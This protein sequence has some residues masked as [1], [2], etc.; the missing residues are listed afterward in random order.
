MNHRLPQT[1]ARRLFLVLGVT[2]IV[3][4][5]LEVWLDH[6][7][8]SDLWVSHVLKED[9]DGPLKLDV[10]FKDDPGYGPSYLLHMTNTSNRP[11]IFDSTLLDVPNV[12]LTC[13]SKFSDS[14]SGV[15]DRIS[16]Q[17]NS[18]YVMKPGEVL[19]ETA[20]V[21]GHLRF[22]LYGSYQLNYEATIHYDVYDGPNRGIF[23]DPLYPSHYPGK[24]H[25]SVEGRCLVPI[26]EHL[27]GS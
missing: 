10:E 3:L 16:G 1:Q 11:L 15:F 12:R 17:L 14:R 24:L 22:W 19:D 9:R 7:K 13:D 4:I 8:P 2:V 18:Y 27:G 26:D 23:A 5:G 20:P 25:S 6:G 21:Y